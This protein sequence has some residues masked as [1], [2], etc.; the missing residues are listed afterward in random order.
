M[1]AR[2]LLAVLLLTG[3]GLTGCISG[4]D[5]QDEGPTVNQTGG[6][7]TEVPDGRGKIIA[8]EETNQTE[9][10]VGGVDHH[11]DQWVG[12]TRVVVFEKDAMM[13]PGPD[14][15][16]AVA[17]FRPPQGVYIFEGTASVEFTLSEPRRHAC[18]GFVTQNGHYLCTDYLGDGTPA[19]PAASDP[20][21]GPTGLKLRYKH[22][23][24]SEWIDVGEIAWGTPNVIKITD[25][26]ET[27][28]P[29]ATSSIW[30]FQVISPNPH[31]ST[32]VFKA[33]AEMVRGEGEIPL[34]PGHPLFYDENRTSRVVVDNVDAESCGLTSCALATEPGAVFAS[35][36][37]SY[38]TR[39]LFIWANISSV[40]APNPASA[41]N[42]WYVYHRNATG[43]DNITSPFDTVNYGMDKK[44][45]FWI[46]PVDDGGMDSPYADASRWNFELGASWTTPNPEGPR[47]AIYSG[48]ADY[49]VKYTLTVHASSLDLPAEMY[50]MSCLDEQ[51]YCPQPEEAAPER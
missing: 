50:H 34:W 23:S 49:A 29:H 17:T 46:I 27:D 1:A 45:L 7:N 43:E 13:D 21:G 38:G 44:N 39:S 4:D 19:A 3:A 36:L 18:E 42:S 26:K 35:K 11:H 24:T 5:P 12:R 15:S 32:L 10:G 2:T 28:M 30:E 41:P 48:F 9:S 14:S 22:A 40:Q 16:G 31:D 8:F 33:K 20:T 47:Y 51:V 37:V 25:P 6:L